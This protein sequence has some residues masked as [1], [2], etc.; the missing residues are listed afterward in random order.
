MVTGSCLEGDPPEAAGRDSP[1]VTCG[2]RPVGSGAWALARLACLGRRVDFVMTKTTA[3]TRWLQTHSVPFE[4]RTYAYVDRGGAK[5]AARQ[6]DVP[7]EQV[8]KTLVME[9]AD[10][11]P[12]LI[13]MHGDREVS[14]KH[15]A[16]ALGTKSVRPC[17]PKR[18]QNVSG[19]QVGGTSPFGTKQALR[20]CYEESLGPCPAIWINGGQRGVLVGLSGASFLAAMEALGAQSV[21]CG[22]AP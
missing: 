18:A 22:Q 11:T 1:S 20:V 19:Y 15:L 14:A 2:F 13:L 6:L 8:V 16:R 21:Q 5:E 4:Q 10:G 12:L 9:D 17:T 7:L 3:A